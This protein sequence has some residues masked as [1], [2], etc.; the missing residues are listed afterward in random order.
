[1]FFYSRTADELALR[2]REVEAE[3]SDL[4]CEQATL[5]NELD[6]IHVAGR[7]GHR[8]MNEWLSAEL[9]V[10]RTFASDLVF[11]ARNLVKDRPLNA[12]LG[13]GDV[14]FDR[15][16]ALMRLADA[17]ADAATLS[18]SETMDLPAVRRLIATQRRITRIT[19][20]QAFTERFVTVQAT[21]DESS[22]RFTGQLA[23]VDGDVFER[24]L[25]ARADELRLLPGGD[26]YTRGQLQADAL[27]AM[28]HDSLNR[29]R[30]GEDTPGGGSVSILVDLDAANGT[31]GESGAQVEYGPRVGPAALEELLCTGTVQI[32][33]LRDGDP[34]VTSKASR[35][36]P[37]AVRRLVATRDGGCT[38]A[39]CVSRYRLEPHHIVLRSNGGSHDPENLTTLCWFHHHI[40]IH[41]Q[42]LRIDPNSPPLKRRLIRPRPG[43]DPPGLE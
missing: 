42:G 4:R 34:V 25:Y 36:I 17:G 22:R 11:C 10:S 31:G 28:A 5:V 39:G 43:H 20:H 40:A 32:I 15:A 37:P 3:I 2:L 35:A 27:V 38:I 23:G 13:E 14:T 29:T 9:D 12:R 1:M 26:G 19:A 24:A 30:N 6:K 8:S 16:V 33:G 7:T 18:H 21:L 41:Q